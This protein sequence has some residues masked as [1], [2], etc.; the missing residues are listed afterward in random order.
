MDKELVRKEL[1]LSL[2]L[3]WGA[4]IED[5]ELDKLLS[6]GYIYVQEQY[7]NWNKELIAYKKYIDAN[8]FVDEEFEKS[9]RTGFPLEDYIEIYLR[10]L[11][12]RPAYYDGETYNESEYVKSHGKQFEMS[13]LATAF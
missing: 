9:I 12:G 13:K 5:E 3:K 7:K 6:S 4:D 8:D 2:A 10:D 11:V 1:R